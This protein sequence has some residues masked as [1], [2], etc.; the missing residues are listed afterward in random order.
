[1]RVEAFC[2]VNRQSD[3]Q[4]VLNRLGLV[5][6][7]IDFHLDALPGQVGRPHEQEAVEAEFAFL[8]QQPDRELD[9]V[10]IVLVDM[11]RAVMEIEASWT[12]CSIQ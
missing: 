9:G 2:A 12:S 6:S 4:L 3:R 10:R 7:D 1:M 8:L 11:D 5:E